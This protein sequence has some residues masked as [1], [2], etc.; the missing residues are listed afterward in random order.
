MLDTG[1]KVGCEMNTMSVIGSARARVW[2]W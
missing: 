1:L 2:R